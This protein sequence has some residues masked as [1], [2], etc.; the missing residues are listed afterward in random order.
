MS[1]EAVVGLV[2]PDFYVADVIGMVFC[3]FVL[4]LFFGTVFVL[5]VCFFKVFIFMRDT[6]SSPILTDYP[7]PRSISCAS[8][9]LSLLLNCLNFPQYTSGLIPAGPVV[10]WEP[11]ESS[12]C[13]Q[14][15]FKCSFPLLGRI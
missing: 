12:D 5:F 2:D 7:V 14:E 13:S 1:W 9:L 3:L 8:P 15:L 11:A 10:S 4:V 6:V